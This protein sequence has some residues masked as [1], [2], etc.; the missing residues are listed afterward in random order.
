[1]IKDY[2]YAV[3][4][5]K[6][7]LTDGKVITVEPDGYKKIIRFF[8]AEGDAYKPKDIPMETIEMRQLL[9]ISVKS[10]NAKTPSEDF[11]V[12]FTKVLKAEINQSLAPLE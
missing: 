3:V 8:L 1:M 6:A 5:F 4:L 10:Q 7:M 12:S 2:A 11:P 9:R